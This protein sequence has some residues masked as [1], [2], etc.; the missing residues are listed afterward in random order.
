MTYYENKRVQNQKNYIKLRKSIDLLT[1]TTYIIKN[2]EI[3]EYDN[4]KI[5]NSFT[6]NL[7]PISTK[8]KF[9]SYLTCRVE[10]IH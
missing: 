1:K 5:N 7:K 10:Y 4:Y 3:P 2:D 9:K 8:K 6:F